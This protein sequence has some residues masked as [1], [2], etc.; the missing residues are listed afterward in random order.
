MVLLSCPR[1]CRP[2]LSARREGG[3]YFQGA[4]TVLLLPDGDFSA[5]HA[6]GERVRVGIVNW[7]ES[8]ELRK[9][10]TASAAVA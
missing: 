7:R 4:K 8:E 10:L 6:C 1:C 3:Y 2:L 5:V 9:V